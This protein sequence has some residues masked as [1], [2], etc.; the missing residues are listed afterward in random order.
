MSKIVVE[1]FMVIYLLACFFC[2]KRRQEI[3]IATCRIHIG[4]ILPQPCRLATYPFPS[5]NDLKESAYHMFEFFSEDKE[6]QQIYRYQ[7]TR[8]LRGEETGPTTGPV[9]EAVGLLYPWRL[10]RW[11]CLH[12]WRSFVTKQKAFFVSG[13]SDVSPAGE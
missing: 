8:L 5:L 2:P 9:I 10:T 12:A 4:V 1:R 6:Q 7:L 13:S 3:R 11:Y